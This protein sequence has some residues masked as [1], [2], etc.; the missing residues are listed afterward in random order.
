MNKL[1]KKIVR[2][3]SVDE[4]CEEYAVLLEYRDRLSSIEESF[5]DKILYTKLPIV[6]SDVAVDDFI[7]CYESI[8]SLREAFS[9][10]TALWY[11]IMVTELDILE[12]KM[13]SEGFD[14]TVEDIYLDKIDK[15]RKTLGESK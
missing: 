1:Y 12:G 14:P 15:L 13:K 7:E 10:A 9:L 8:K 5:E 6:T 2:P 11:K 4:L 3:Q